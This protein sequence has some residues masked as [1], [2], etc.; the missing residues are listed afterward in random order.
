MSSPTAAAEIVPSSE[1]VVCQVDHEEVVEPDPEVL[2]SGDADVPP[3]E[4][5]TTAPTESAPPPP[6]A[7][8]DLEELRRQEAQD[9]LALEVTKKMLQNDKKEIAIAKRASVKAR[10]RSEKRAGL[11]QIVSKPFQVQHL[12]H[13]DRDYNWTNVDPDK[14][15]EKLDKLGEGSFGSVYKVKHR[16]LGLIFASKILTPEGITSTLEKEI[17]VLMDY[18]ALGSLRDIIE[19][20]NRTLYEDEIASVMEGALCG[21]AYLHQM[22]IAHLDVKGGNI[23][24]T[25]ECCVKLTD[26]GVSQELNSTPLRRKHSAY[27]DFAVLGSSIGTPLWMAPEII[28]KKPHT[29][30]ADIWSLGITIIELAEGRPPGASGANPLR[31]VQMIPNRNPPTLQDS[32]WSKDMQLFLSLCLTKDPIKRANAFELLNNAFIIKRAGQASKLLQSLATEYLSRKQKKRAMAELEQ[33]KMEADKVKEPLPRAAEVPSAHRRLLS[34]LFPIADVAPSEA[35]QTSQPSSDHSAAASTE[36]PVSKTLP[37]SKPNSSAGSKKLGGSSPLEP[38]DVPERLDPC[39]TVVHSQSPSHST[40]LSENESVDSDLCGTTIVYS[41]KASNSNSSRDPDSDS[42]C[43]TIV[44]TTDTEGISKIPKSKPSPSFAQVGE[45]MKRDILSSTDTFLQK[46]KAD[47]IQETSTL[48]QTFLTSLQTQVREAVS[49][50]LKSLARREDLTTR[51]EA[52]STQV[53]DRTAARLAALSSAAQ[54]AATAKAEETTQQF[55]ECVQSI[56]SIALRMETLVQTYTTLLSHNTNLTASAP[57]TT[58]KPPSRPPPHSLH[59]STTSNK[60]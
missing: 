25:K 43:S 50:E 57:T 18:C 6:R 27:G 12:V 29:E 7:P 53:S 28:L 14:A 52:Y 9:R 24:M 32:T 15:F 60:M 21:L 37:T 56:D 58:P 10:R 2:E 55:Q 48:H 11:E 35:P 31:Y 46:L 40:P 45:S 38:T 44:H 26:F 16:E 19:T 59:V 1:N 17:A 41:T 42:L 22:N 20:C 33:A 36:P 47:I 51:L 5:D 23:L 4:P 8:M 39:G 54:T 13:I 30:K 49:E 3:A 34:K